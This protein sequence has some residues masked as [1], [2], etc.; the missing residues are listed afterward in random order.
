MVNKKAQDLSIGTLILIVLGIIVL[1]LLILGFSM[2]WGNLWE[3]I[4]IFGG[5]SS[6]NDVVTSCQLAVTSKNTYSFCQEFRKIKVGSDVEYLNCEDARV[7]ASLDGELSCTKPEKYLTWR[8][9][10][11]TEKLTDKEREKNVKVNNIVCTPL[12]CANTEKKQAVKNT[13]EECKDIQNA[14]V[15]KGT[16]SDVIDSS[17]VCCKLL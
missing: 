11:C 14:I 6:V 4:N 17:Q 10:Y 16:F 1:V 8:E 12:P 15:V 3:K 9:L 5:S 2:G 7:K 13:E